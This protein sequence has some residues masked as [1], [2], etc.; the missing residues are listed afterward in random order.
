MPARKEK[1]LISLDRCLVLI[2]WMSVCVCAH[3]CKTDKPKYKGNTKSHQS[4]SPR[5]G[6]T[7]TMKNPN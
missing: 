3:E 4:L 2:M 1:D 5:L 7:C 6:N